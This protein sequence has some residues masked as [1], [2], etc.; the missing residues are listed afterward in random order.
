MD[1]TDGVDAESVIE[2]VGM[3][4]TMRQAVGVCR[5]GGTI[6]CVGMPHGVSFDG[7]QIFFCQQRT[8]GSPAPVRRFLPDLMNLVLPGKI[9]PGLVF[10][11]ILPLDKV[12]EGHKAT[13]ERRAIKAMLTV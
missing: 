8:Q 12:A 11:L 5:R 4:V 2:A 10:D 7:Q 6:G 9:Q 13:E 1:L 3:Q